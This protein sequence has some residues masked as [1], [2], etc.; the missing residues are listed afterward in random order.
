MSQKQSIIFWLGL[1]LILVMT[2]FPP[3]LKTVTADETGVSTYRQIVHY[4]YFFTKTAKKIFLQR[5]F[6]QWFIVAV[7]TGGLM[8]TYKPRLE[9]TQ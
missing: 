6:I 1:I 3:I 8:Y 4:E 5:L 7:V 9:P 2:V